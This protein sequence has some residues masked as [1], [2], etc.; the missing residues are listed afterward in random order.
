MAER[1][2]VSEMIFMLENNEFVLS[3]GKESDLEGV[4]EVHGCLPALS[5][6][7]VSESGC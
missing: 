4:E 1:F 3:S 5:E 6:I 2:R 7:P